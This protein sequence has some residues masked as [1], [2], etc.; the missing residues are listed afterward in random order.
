MRSSPAIGADG[1]IYMG[2][3]DNKLHAV[4]P[5]R[6][7]NWTY[8]TGDHVSSTPAIGADGT[9]YVG[10]NDGKLY[11]FNPDGT[12]EW[13]YTTEESVESSPAIGADGTI[14]VGSNDI[15]LH[16][17]KPDGT[18][19]WT[20]TTGDNV[21]SSP[22][23]GADGTI[24]VGSRDG[25]LH[26]VHP[27]FSHSFF[28]D[29]RCFLDGLSDSISFSASVYFEQR[30]PSGSTVTSFC[31]QQWKDHFCDVNTT[32]GYYVRD[33]FCEA[34]KNHPPYSC[35]RDVKR[36]IL[37][38]VSLSFSFAELVYTLLLFLCVTFSGH[39]S[40]RLWLRSPLINLDKEAS[41]YTSTPRS[42]TKK[43][44]CTTL[45]NIDHTRFAIRLFSLCVCLAF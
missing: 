6:T 12:Q 39:G 40:G 17:V 4:N 9:I 23:I 37:E 15:K 8:T 1:T 30:L 7:P 19:K 42:Q 32:Q 5:D 41:R 34:F 14:Y 45:R 22:T 38:A 13:N 36:S 24:Y 35:A 33:A 3:N 18:H 21:Y 27:K 31:Q 28:G 29:D 10:S 16:T 44:I 2:S 20:Y 26:I 25:K 43:D 11:A